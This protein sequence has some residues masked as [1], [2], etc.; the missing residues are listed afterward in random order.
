MQN[1]IQAEIK[2]DSTEVQTGIGHMKSLNSETEKLETSNKRRSAAAAKADNVNYNA[3]RALGGGTGAA[4]RDF[5]NEARA[6]GGLVAVYAQ[7]AATV[8][9]VEAAFRKLKDAA[10]V[11][12]MTKGMDQLASKSGVAL[13]SLSR[14]FVRAT[15][16]AISLKDGIDAVAKASNAGL[17]NQ[18]ILNIASGAQK[19]AIALGR[20]LNDSISRVTRGV[21]KLQPELLDELGLYSKLGPATEK[22]AAKLGVSAHQL[23]ETQRSQAYAVAVLKELNQKYGD[24]K[25]DANPYDKLL[26]SLT[27][28]TQ[29]GLNFIN[30]FLKPLANILGD[31]P[32]ALTGAIGILASSILGKFLPA[33]G[34]LRE[35]TREQANKL[36][37]VSKARAADSAKSLSEAKSAAIEELKIK[38][39][40]YAQDKDAAVDAAQKRLEA[41]DKTN[42]T[43][44]ARKIISNPDIEKITDKQLDYLK[45]QATKKTK[46]GADAYQG[47]VNAVTE[48]KKAQL[49]YFSSIHDAEIKASKAPGGFWDFSPAGMN[50]KASE[51]ARQNAAGANIVATAAETASL[52]GF[53][54]AFG[55]MISGIKTEQLSPVKAVFTGISGTA[56][57]AAARLVQFAG[58]VGTIGMVIGALA[59]VKAI[60]DQ[61][62]SGTAQSAAE[63]TQN[64]EQLTSVTKTAKDVFER[65]KDTITTDSLM[66]K[67]KAINNILASIADTPNKLD[68]QLK[69]QTWWDKIWD[70]MP[71]F[72][73]G[74]VENQAS[75][76]LGKGISGVIDNLGTPEQK[77]QAKK[78]LASILNITGTDEKD[79]IEG[80]KKGTTATRN[81]AVGFVEGVGKDLEKIASPAQKVR[82]NFAALETSYLHMRNSFISTDVGVKFATDLINQLTTIGKAFDNPVSKLAV[83]RE[84]AKDMSQIKM[85]PG[86]TQKELTDA[87]E[88]I[89]AIEDQLNAAR[90]SRDNAEQKLKDKGYENG[91][92][93]AS[94][95]TPDAVAGRERYA[96]IN[97][98]AWKRIRETA[99]DA[100]QFQ[101]ANTNIDRLEKQ[102]LATSNGFKI[103]LS[104]GIDAALKLIE[105]PLSR[106]LQ[107]AR[108]DSSKAIISNLPET[109]AGIKMQ[110]DLEL[111]SIQIRKA[112]IVALKSLETSLTLARIAGERGETTRLLE[113][114]SRDPEF[115]RRLLAKQ[116]DLDQQEKAARGTITGKEAAKA[117]GTTL[118]IFQSNQGFDAKLVGLTSQ[119]N[120]DKIKS[121]VTANIFKFTQVQKDLEQKLAVLQAQNTQEIESDAFKSLS[122]AEQDRKKAQLAANE[123][124]LKDALAQFPAIINLEKG[125]L[126]N[127]YVNDNKKQFGDK[128][129]GLLKVGTE[130]QEQGTKQL[131]A[132]ETAR[133][134]QVG[135]TATVAE[136]AAAAAELTSNNKANDVILAETQAKNIAALQNSLNINQ[137]KKTTLE[138]L[139]SIGGVTEQDYFSQQ[140]ALT[141]SDAQLERDKQILEI[142]N[143]QRLS[144]ERIQ[145]AE[146]AAGG[147]NKKEFETQR[148]QVNTDAKDKLDA[149]DVETKKRVDQAKLV[150]DNQ[151]E[152]ALREQAYNQIFIKG[153]DTTTDKF[154]EFITT[155]KTSFKG[156]V[157]SMIADL[158]RYELRQ[159]LLKIYEGTGGASGGAT[160]GS[161]LVASAV[162]GFK[163]LFGSAQ[164]SAWDQGV[165]KYAKGGIVTQPTLF[166]FAKGTGMMGEAGPEAIMPLRRDGAGNLGVINGG[167]GKVDVVVNNYSNQQATTKESMDAKGN[168]KIEVIVGDMVADQLSKTGSSAQ[169]SLSSNYG[170]RPALVRR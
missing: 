167:G 21:A 144:L 28:L 103:N 75:E 118:A 159:N 156:L 71:Q 66:A 88:K 2:L 132:L 155:G 1:T 61:F 164:G 97:T 133:K 69:D 138:F 55:E 111:E 60:G 85:F 73:G 89:K 50:A 78:K 150:R 101:T 27:N 8:F 16:D 32:V 67:S 40:K 70:V 131:N 117:G 141:I 52:R 6:L 25:V 126:S 68:R 62:F 127:E 122:D 165:M 42:I 161:S 98:P 41:I 74:H 20:D 110:T 109:A 108:I 135:T 53:G 77:E 44:K 26:A 94:L 139:K 47:F 19:A 123:Q 142:K 10:D 9:A 22:Y 106:A 34:Q 3:A 87:A 116:D 35:S 76:V 84:L 23:T 12:N 162:S 49:D 36:A 83:M 145:E 43:D 152:N 92:A 147:E 120:V 129:P 140:A 158:I 37:E 11:Q 57:A 157:D 51:K 160:L 166:K 128:V 39:D 148:N 5:G 168:R 59:A 29:T 72:V 45:D 33:V 86:E 81:A 46:A 31:N 114:P 112:E 30:F 64:L 91:Q 146:K 18:Q 137:A 65:Y 24:I 48:A 95:L 136:R 130:A 93:A 38:K 63:L 58:A 104:S 4:G 170:N 17:N 14:E 79:I 143:Q 99:A 125:K 13:G 56:T 105:G 96:A 134:L 102:L 169:Q 7:Y 124:V 163:S 149:I 15:G 113:S 107:Q 54:A 119:A 90:A 80:I 82:E 153:I 100:Q 151:T 154:M 121:Y 115:R